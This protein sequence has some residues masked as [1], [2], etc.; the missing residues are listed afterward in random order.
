MVIIQLCNA[1]IPD[2]KI[3][4]KHLCTTCYNFDKALD[5]SLKRN[6]YCHSSGTCKPT[7]TNTVF[8]ITASD[9]TDHSY[10]TKTGTA[11]DLWGTKQNTVSGNKL[12]TTYKCGNLPTDGASGWTSANA[13]GDSG[14]SYC[15]LE[16]LKKYFA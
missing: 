4:V 13:Y 16:K 8:A 14:W 2:A 5:F 15:K 11:Y 7:G 3:V 12:V 1:W 6:E 9:L 10:W